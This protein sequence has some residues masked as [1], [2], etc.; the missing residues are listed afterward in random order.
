MR[1]FSVQ[2][3]TIQI[4]SVG[5]ERRHISVS[6]FAKARLL[7]LFRNF[8]ILDFSVLNSKQQRLIAQTWYTGTNAGPAAADDPFDLIGTIDGF[9]PKLYPPSVFATKKPDR[10]RA[11][12]SSLSGLRT[13]AIWTVMVVLLL[14][15]AIYLVPKHGFIPQPPVAAATTN[16]V[17]PPVRYVPPIPAKLAPPVMQA[18]VAAPEVSTVAPTVPPRHLPDAMASGVSSLEV[19]PPEIQVSTKP[20]GRREVMIRVSVNHQG[21]AERFEVLQGDRGKISAALEAAQAWH[22]QPCSSAD[23]CEHTL[24]I[25]NYEDASIVQMID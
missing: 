6:G 25:K 3:E 24:R 15:A 21:Q 1:D 16:A 4:A 23:V 18:P 9:L 12:S 20:A 2:C 14:G 11:S 7:W 19:K 17:I 10:T 22:F 13:P 5:G 8:R